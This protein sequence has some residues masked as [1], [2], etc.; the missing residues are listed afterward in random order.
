VGRRRTIELLCHFVCGVGIF[1]KAGVQTAGLL[2]SLQ[3]VGILD[4]CAI[5]RRCAIK[6]QRMWP[7][8]NK[9]K[10]SICSQCGVQVLLDCSPDVYAVCDVCQSA[11]GPKGE[12]FASFTLLTT[13]V[14]D[15]ERGCCCRE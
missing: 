11:T 13:D 15:T 5:S 14:S 3:V 9:Q 4:P 12:E 10:T 1:L 8:R 6:L 7:L 2:G